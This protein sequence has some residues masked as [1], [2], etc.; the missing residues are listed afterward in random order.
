MHVKL[1]QEGAMQES[2]YFQEKEITVSIKGVS[3][4]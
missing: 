2:R 4:I 3:D 1:S